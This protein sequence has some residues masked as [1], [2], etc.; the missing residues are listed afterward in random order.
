ML[1]ITISQACYVM[2]YQKDAAV[3]T[4]RLHRAS[5]LHGHQYLVTTSAVPA[6]SNK[7]SYSSFHR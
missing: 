2:N 6:I 5:F 3:Q 4:L 7:I 1:D